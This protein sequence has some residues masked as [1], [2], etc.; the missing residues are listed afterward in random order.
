MIIWIFAEGWDSP[1]TGEDGE[2]AQFT[3]GVGFGVRGAHVGVALTNPSEQLTDG[4]LA[5][6]CL[7]DNGKPYP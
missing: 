1:L 6:K 7:D 2:R 5:R 4:H 3:H